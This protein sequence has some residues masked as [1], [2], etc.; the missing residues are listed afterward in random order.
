M[1]RIKEKVGGWYLVLDNNKVTTRSSS[2]LNMFSHVAFSIGEWNRR[3]AQDG[4]VV[5][6]GTWI[7][8]KWITGLAYSLILLGEMPDKIERG[9]ICDC[10]YQQGI[11]VIIA[12]LGHPVPK[13]RKT[14]SLNDLISGNQKFAKMGIYDPQESIIKQC[15]NME[16]HDLLKLITKLNTIAGKKLQ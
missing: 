14:V 15:E 12:G 5:E 9:F 13:P 4:A 16:V 11:S 10:P 3:K 1:E 7:A 6:I 2:G 8:G